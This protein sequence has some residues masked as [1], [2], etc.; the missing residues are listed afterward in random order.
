M[1]NIRKRPLSDSPQN[2]EMIRFMT[3][4]IPLLIKSAIKKTYLIQAMEF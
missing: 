4:G 1:K 2:N 3:P